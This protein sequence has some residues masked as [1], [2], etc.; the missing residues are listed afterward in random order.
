M[1]G[2]VQMRMGG[3]RDNQG[4]IGNGRDWEEWREEEEVES[5]GVWSDPGMTC[6][7]AYFWLSIHSYNCSVDRR[8]KNRMSHC[9]AT[10]S[11]SSRFCLIFLRSRQ[12]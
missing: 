10:C 2:D 12:R 1:V 7:R 11:W 5:G 3:G 8:W 4:G 6:R 9:R